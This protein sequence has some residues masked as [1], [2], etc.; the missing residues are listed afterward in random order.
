ML[1]R[2]WKRKRISRYSLK[3]IYWYDKSFIILVLSYVHANND[4]Q[5][6][7]LLN[8]SNFENLFPFVYFDLTKQKMDSKDAVTKLA[9]HYELTANPNADYNIYAL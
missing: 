9:F 7:T 3:T 8:R 5:G 6:G 1:F 2:S 4:Y